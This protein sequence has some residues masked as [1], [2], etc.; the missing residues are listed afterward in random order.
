MCHHQVRGIA[1]LTITE[2]PAGR[3]SVKLELDGYDDANGSMIVEGGRL[4]RSNR[5]LSKTANL[6]QKVLVEPGEFR[7]GS[8]KPRLF[9]RA[10]KISIS[11][12]FYMSTYEVTRYEWLKV[13]QRPT[14]DPAA[15]HGDPFR[16]MT[17]VSWFDAH[18]R[19]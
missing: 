6:I 17:G 5:G 18:L 1:P 16:P 9:A 14:S 7:V 12:A 4:S 3:V 10:N 19:N 15:T 8:N 11:R 13:M 2:I